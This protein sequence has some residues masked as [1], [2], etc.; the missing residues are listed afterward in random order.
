MDNLC[1]IQS[2]VLFLIMLAHYSLLV[3][4]ITFWSIDILLLDIF[5]KFYALGTSLYY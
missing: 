3:N 1:I 2:T 5:Q 4:F